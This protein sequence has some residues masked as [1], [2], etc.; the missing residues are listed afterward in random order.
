MSYCYMRKIHVR[1]L[2]KI[3]FFIFKNIY[4]FIFRDG[5]EK[6]KEREQNIDAQEKH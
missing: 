5:E 4:L 6:K 2:A 1:K 3:I